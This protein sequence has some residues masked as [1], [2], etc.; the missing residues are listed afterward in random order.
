MTG[1]QN[2]IFTRIKSIL[3]SPQWFGQG[4]TVAAPETPLLDSLIQ[5]VAWAL[6]FAYSLY[7]YA[8]L[9]ARIATATDGFLDLIAADYFGASLVRR[10]A[11]SDSSFRNQI[12]GTILKPQATRG[13]M[14]NAL[15]VLTGQTPIVYEPR[16][17]LDVCGYGA[18]L[19]YGIQ[20][21]YGS[22][23]MPY[24]ALV[25]AFRPLNQG[26]PYRSGY[27]NPQ[28]GYGV[29]AGAF[30]WATPDQTT[31]G[32]TDTDI[33][34]AMNNVRPVATTVWARIASPQTEFNIF[35]LDDSE[36]DGLD[37]LG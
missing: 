2:D 3:N 10:Q 21:R 32:V 28:G 22:Q 37:V 15:Q 26:V 30:A 16:R 8:K 13:A 6:S 27:G 14:I 7:A 5:G 12:L 1:D 23:L 36:L 11:Q 35:T 20:G 17:P 29:A 31:G 18:G 4:E 24:Q 9:Q 33:I 34:A 25:V 19:Y